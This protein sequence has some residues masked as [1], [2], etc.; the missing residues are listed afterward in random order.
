MYGVPDASASLEQQQQLVHAVVIADMG[1][2]AAAV[3]ALAGQYVWPSCLL[4]LLT[5]N[6]QHAP[7]CNLPAADLAAI[8]AADAGG[9]VL[10]AVWEDAEMSTLLLGPPLPAMQLLLSPDQLRDPSEDTVLYAAKP[11]LRAR[12]QAADE[13]A[14]KAALASLIRALSLFQLRGAALPRGSEQQLLGSYMQNLRGLVRPLAGGVTLE[15]RLPL[16]QLKEACRMQVVCKREGGGN[17]IGVFAGPV[18]DDMPADHCYSFNFELT[19]ENIKRKASSPVRN[20]SKTPNWGFPNY[21]ELRPMARGW[22]EAAWM[23]TA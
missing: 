15:W 8:K 13:A 23:C 6:V 16:E 14:A 19:V 12:A 1:L 22:D 7:C 20:S 18:P 17:K 9:R 10:Q 3:Q 2:S 11:F 4:Q 21:F 5:T